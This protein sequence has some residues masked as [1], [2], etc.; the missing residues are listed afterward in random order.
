MKHLIAF[1]C[2][3]LLAFTIAA[4]VKP[5]TAPVTPPLPTRIA[6]AAAISPPQLGFPVQVQPDPG[7]YHYFYGNDAHFNF[8][9]VPN[10][11]TPR[12]N[13][14]F[15][16]DG[17]AA[18]H[19]SDPNGKPTVIVHDTRKRTNMQL[20]ILEGI[21]YETW[22]NQQTLPPATNFMPFGLLLSD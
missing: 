12:S 10:A 8:Y 15:L 16:A 21:S 19:P 11:N 4:V 13:W 1:S 22:S 6:S 20:I 5:T 17:S 18:P 14:V 7:I 3:A 9:S 2:L